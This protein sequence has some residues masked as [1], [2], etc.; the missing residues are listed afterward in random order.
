MAEARRGSRSR[1]RR[2]LASCPVSSVDDGEDVD[3]AVGLLD[4]LDLAH[5][6]DL[7]VAGRAAVTSGQCQLPSGSLTRLRS[8]RRPGPR[9]AAPGRR[10]SRSRPRRSRRCRSGP[11]A[12]RGCAGRSRRPV[13]RR[14][15]RRDGR[16]S[17]STSTSDTLGEDVERV[18]VA[19][20]SPRCCRSPRT[21]RCPTGCTSEGDGAVDAQL[22]VSGSP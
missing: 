17:S 10:R 14:R 13:R 8:R 11:S 4:E 18:A 19:G 21:S 1:D 15:R 5:R 20:S 16:R 7:L 3:L 9:S 12:W 22:R 2:L 6:R